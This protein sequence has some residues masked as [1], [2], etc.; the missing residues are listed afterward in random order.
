MHPLLLPAGRIRRDELEMIPEQPPAPGGAA[1]S[2][3]GVD[4]PEAETSS[5]DST[6]EAWQEASGE[7][8]GLLQVERWSLAGPGGA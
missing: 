1:A 2:G 3:R 8:E 4:A 6:E 5:C 7:D